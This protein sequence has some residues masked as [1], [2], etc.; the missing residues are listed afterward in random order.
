MMDGKRTVG[1][2]HPHTLRW[3]FWGKGSSSS[4]IVI[5]IPESTMCNSKLGFK[6]I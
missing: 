3:V 2:K 5:S 6:F 1:L 4:R